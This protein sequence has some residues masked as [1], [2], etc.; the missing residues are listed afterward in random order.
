MA[1]STTPAPEQEQSSEP[2]R[3]L[4][5][6]DSDDTALLVGKVLLVQGYEL[7]SR[8]T[9]AHEAVELARKLKP[10]LV[11]MDIFLDGAVD[12]IEAARAIRGESDCAIVF[13]T[14]HTSDDVLDRAR[15]ADPHGYLVKPV[16]PRALRPT[17][18]IALHK[19]RIERERREATEQLQAA[20]DEVD[21]LRGLL[22]MCAWCRR[23][24]DD[25][26]YWGSLEQYVARRL[27]TRYTHGICKECLSQIKMERM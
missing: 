3:I 14:G 13:L 17:I 2:V 27:N 19:A 20:L 4:V 15:S 11:L 22:P 24:R 25:A 12:G 21:L 5:V 1:Q 10:D 6:E 9:S 26:G 7:T 18:E 8:A 16:E 23:V